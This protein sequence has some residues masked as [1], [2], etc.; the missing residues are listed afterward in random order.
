MVG[1]PLA[2]LHILKVMAIFS[3]KL[4]LFMKKIGFKGRALKHQAEKDI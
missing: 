1:I 3:A 4:Q 2:G